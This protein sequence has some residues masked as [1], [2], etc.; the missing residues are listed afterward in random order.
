M[1]HTVDN[2]AALHAVLSKVALSAEHTSMSAWSKNLSHGVA[3]HSGW[4]PLLQRVGFLRKAHRSASNLQA[5]RPS[6]IG[7]R[8]VLH[9]GEGKQPY[10]IVPIRGTPLLKRK[11]QQILNLNSIS[12]KPPR[13]WKEWCDGLQELLKAFKEHPALTGPVQGY[14]QL[15]LARSFMFLLRMRLSAASSK[16]QVTPQVGKMS[17]TQFAS[18]APDQ[19]D[20]VTHFCGRAG[21]AKSLQQLNYRGP[22]ELFSMKL[23]LYANQHLTWGSAQVNEHRKL[24]KQLLGIY[25]IEH[26]IAP[27]PAVL[28][29]LAVEALLAK[30]CQRS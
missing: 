8:R 23:C 30:P 1:Q 29:N 5:S 12:L 3:H 16:L 4:L 21:V 18:M 15:W 19:G 9:L 20:W 26:G 14:S 2:P 25:I 6:A 28:Q 27:H 7:T 22:L 24:L 17:V 11:L 13:T 10:T